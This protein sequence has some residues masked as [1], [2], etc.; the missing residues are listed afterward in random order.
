MQKKQQEK[1]LHWAD[2]MRAL[3]TIS[4]VLLHTAAGML[5]KY[6]SIPNHDWN[7]GNAYDSIVR[8]CV[9][10]FL[11]ISGALLL[12]KEYDIIDF[13]KK[14]VSRIILP[15][16]F[17]SIFYIAYDLRESFIGANQPGVL[18]IIKKSV[19]LLIQGSSFHFWY[20]YMIIGVYM[21]I[22]IIGHWVRNCKQKEIL[23]FLIV[24]SC[25]LFFNL[26]I[27]SNYKI[28][29]EISYF[30]GY[31]GYVV[32]GYYLSMQ[33]YTNIKKIKIIAI[34]LII[35][36][37]GSTF[38]GTAIASNHYHKFYDILYNYLTLN[39]M[40]SA[41]G[42]FL[43]V[44]NIEVVNPII[45]K[46]RDYIGKYSYGIYLSH[47]LFIYSLDK[48]GISWGLFTPIIGI[49]ISA[50]LCLSISSFVVFIVNKLPGGKYIS[51]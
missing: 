4:V 46:I 42:V 39:V 22:P 48:I 29:I 17:W 10:L 20:V 32:L 43:L 25:T 13:L 50:F 15:F 21:F 3:A 1:N 12:P 41:V 7:I 14:R 37:I 33:S 2:N 44:K 28:P 19:T 26:P 51:G 31:I 6:G 16:L 30:T 45:I 9:P 18:S 24:W 11:M 35:S 38:L 5:Y 36:G 27:I 34:L 8:F 49:P 23:Y 40:I 47:M